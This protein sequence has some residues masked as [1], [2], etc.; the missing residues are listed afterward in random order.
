M[1]DPKLGELWFCPKGHLAT[2]TE[3]EI[4]RHRMAR[5]YRNRPPV[6]MDKACTP[7]LPRTLQERKASQLRRVHRGH[8]RPVYS[9][10]LAGGLEAAQE[11]FQAMRR[12][13]K[14]AVAAVARVNGL[15]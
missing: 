10:W 6:C 14:A 3:S 11:V 7:S 15:V 12:A 1:S 4:R 2:F 13:R 9:A 8:Y 5:V